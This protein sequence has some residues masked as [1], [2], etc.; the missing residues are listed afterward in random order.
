M[1]SSNDVAST[2]LHGESALVPPRPLAFLVLAAAGLAVVAVGAVATVRLLLQVTVPWADLPRHWV[3]LLAAIGLTLASLG[4]RSLRW[5]FLLRRTHTYVPLRDSIII[6]LAGLSLIVVPF[7]AG[8]TFLRAL[9]ARQRRAAAAETVFVVNYWE[10]ALDLVALAGIAGAAALASRGSTGLATGGSTGLA[11]GG[12]TWW[13]IT[14]LALVVLSF[15]SQARQALFAVSANLARFVARPVFGTS[16][17]ISEAGR[18][19][20]VGPAAY[21]VGIALSVAAWILPG[22]GLWGLARAWSGP[23]T[24][25]Q[26]QDAFA[27]ATLLGGVLLAPAGVFVVGMSILARLDALGLDPSAATLV[28]FG[29]RLATAGL[30]IALGFVFVAYHL[31]RRPAPGGSA[32]FD[33]IADVYDAQ[34]PEA[35]RLALVARKTDLIERV[36]APRRR[37][38]GLDVGCGQGHYVARMRELGYD[39]VGIDDSPLQ[40]ERVRERFA[41]APVASLVGP[42]VASVVEPPVASLVEPSVITR[43]SVLQ[44]PFADAEFDFAYCI[45]VLH[46]LDSVET[47]RRAFGEL[48]RVLK[49]GGVLFLH[50]INTRNWLFRFYMGYLFPALNCID[51]GVERWLLPQRLREF[52]SLP[53]AEIEYFTFL[54][55]FLP[56]LLV[57]SLTPIERRLEASRLGRYSAHY[58]AVFEKPG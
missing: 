11:T 43:G 4:V 6:Y 37:L 50:E 38:K 49:P 19:R 52:T 14:A 26:A 44:I 16:P 56:A 22:L 21:T 54:P 12:S 24:V 27:G 7:L 42:R 8:E 28:V 39:V 10:R 46:H 32:H 5:V 15:L 23:V 58:M 57:R 3:A 53:L 2:N 17:S 13:A 31:V 35:R 29:L 41:E 34:I 40:V 36:L 25:L 51:E 47:Q 30:A 1:A 20:L 45:N 9:V 33:A 55:D 48:G 18:R